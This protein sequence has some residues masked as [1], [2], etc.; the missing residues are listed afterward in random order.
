MNFEP[1]TLLI[2]GVVVFIIAIVAVL[3]IKRKKDKEDDKKD[4]VEPTVPSGPIDLTPELGDALE[5][6]TGWL[7]PELTKK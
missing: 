3:L 5:G 4:R 7:D 1:Q 2:I 6:G